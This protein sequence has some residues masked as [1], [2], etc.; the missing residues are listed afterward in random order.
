MSIS[1]IF[2]NPPSRHDELF[3]DLSG[4]KHPR[5]RVHLVPSRDKQTRTFA[6]VSIEKAVATNLV[7]IIV[8]K[9]AEASYAHK[10]LRSPNDTNRPMMTSKRRTRSSVPRRLNYSRVVPRLF[11]QT[12]ATLSRRF[13]AIIVLEL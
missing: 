4:N 3:S 11:R 10:D 13:A 5:Q 2:F 7:N 6:N 8:T 9:K 12:F 1:L